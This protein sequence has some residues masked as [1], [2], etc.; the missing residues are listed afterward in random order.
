[1]RKTVICTSLCAVGA[2]FLFGSMECPAADGHVEL[3]QVL[4]DWERSTAELPKP[5]PDAAFP[6]SFESH[7]AHELDVAARLYGAVTAHKLI[8]DFNW[9]LEGTTETTVVLKGYPRDEVDRL[10]YSAFEITLDR[11]SMRPTSIQFLGT[12][13][14]PRP[15]LV[16][17]RISNRV[18]V[19]SVPLGGDVRTI[20]VTPAD[21]EQPDSP[22]VT[23]DL[24]SILAHWV[25]ATREIRAAEFRF[26]R[27][28][29]DSI[30]QQEIRGQ[31]RFIFEAPG[32]GLYQLEPVELSRDAV[33]RRTSAAGEPYALTP[34]ER[35]TCYWTGTHLVWIDDEQHTYEMMPLPELITG[36]IRPVG[37]WD[38]VWAG[39]AGPQRALPGVID[40][41]TDDFIARFDWTLLR[42][43]DRQ[44]ILQGRPRT[45]DDRFHLSLLQVVLDPKT[46]LTS[47]TRMID[48][49]GNRETVHV[50]EHVRIDRTPTARHADWEP[51]LSQYRQQ[52]PPPPAPPAAMEE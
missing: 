2:F 47:A 14:T 8:E 4:R 43:D 38:R 15:Q 51:D 29:Y 49:G 48:A 33:S 11:Q 34:D 12:D 16:R 24:E 3:L 31:G 1:M 30:Y 32:R 23:A 21:I 5:L 50:F 46:Y 20:A 22:N 39:W 45:D 44:V 10:F 18:N 19:D 27:Y 26:R 41:H 37:S 9:S 40:A 28:V 6:D 35:V 25:R 52:A 42:R 17:L 7:T 13:G 36:D